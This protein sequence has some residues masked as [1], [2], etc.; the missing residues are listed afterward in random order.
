MSE[1]ILA[2]ITSIQGTSNSIEEASSQAI[3]LS[4]QV[5][6]IAEGTMWKGNASAAFVNAVEEFRSHK[7]RLS[8]LLSDIGGNVDMAAMEHE[9]N[10]EEQTSGMNSVASAIA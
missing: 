8:Q 9:S 2:E 10:E 6:S 3:T 1:N 5:L 4:E 7:D